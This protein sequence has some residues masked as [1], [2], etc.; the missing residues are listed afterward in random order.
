MSVFGGVHS[1][2]GERERLVASG[3]S[4]RCLAW[5][6]QDSLRH[7][8]IH[9]AAVVDMSGFG[10]SFRSRRNIWRFVRLESL[11]L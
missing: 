10:C 5:Q 3:E 2:R 7:C 8:F 11:V 1:F 4:E 9:V 6:A